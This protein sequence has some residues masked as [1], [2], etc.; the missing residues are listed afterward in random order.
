MNRDQPGSTSSPTRVD[1]IVNTLSAAKPAQR[2]EH[3][4]RRRTVG[5]LQIVDGE[6]HDLAVSLQS[7]EQIEQLG[8]DGHR[9]GSRLRPKSGLKLIHDP[10]GEERLFLV[11]ASLEH[12]GIR[13]A[14]RETARGGSTF[15]RQGRPRRRP[16]AGGPNELRRV[17][18]RGGAVRTAGR[19]SRRR[20][21]QGQPVEAPGTAVT[22]RMQVA[23]P[24]RVHLSTRVLTVRNVSDCYA[25]DEPARRRRHLARSPVAM[26]TNSRRIH[27]LNVTVGGPV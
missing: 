21:S 3:R 18:H 11:T 14:S 19:R 27:Q 23:V 5:P 12:R 20:R 26:T 17:A 1:T 22:T 24:K 10:V 15:P 7:I 13:S 6:H 9:V 16:L 8:S 2:E 4:S 25:F